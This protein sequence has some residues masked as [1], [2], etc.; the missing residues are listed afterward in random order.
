MH[1]DYGSREQNKHLSIL[2][3]YLVCPWHLE[4]PQPGIEPD[5]S[6]CNN[7]ARSL[8]HCATEELPKCPIFASKK[9]FV[10]FFLKAIFADNYFY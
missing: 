6:C 9:K 8:T 3:Y 4:V 7:N 2:F 10:N 5:P 1:I